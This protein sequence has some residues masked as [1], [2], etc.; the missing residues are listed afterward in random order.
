MEDPAIRKHIV[1]EAGNDARRI[2][3]QDQRSTGGDRQFRMV[4]TGRR[5]VQGKGHKRRV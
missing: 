3:L 5:I 4:G 2:V 1:I